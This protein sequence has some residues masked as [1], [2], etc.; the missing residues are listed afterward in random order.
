MQTVHS[1][2]PRFIGGLSLVAALSFDQPK[3][4]CAFVPVV[5]AQ[6]VWLQRHRS[7]PLAR[8]TLRP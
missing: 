6:C 5:P 3:G 8:S 2:R 4:L 7:V 1:N